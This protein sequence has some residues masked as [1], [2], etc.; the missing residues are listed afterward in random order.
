[1]FNPLF[2]TLQNFLRIPVR[3]LLKTEVSLQRKKA[4]RSVLRLCL[5]LVKS[6]LIRFYF[7]SAL[8]LSAPTGFIVGKRRTSRIEL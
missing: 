6:C 8:S 1:M 7:L 2:V 3:S 4:E 5:V